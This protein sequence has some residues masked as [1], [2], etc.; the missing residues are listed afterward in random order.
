MRLL[1][2]LILSVL[3]C[4][5]AMAAAVYT[6]TLH[7]QYKGPAPVVS[8]SSAQQKWLQQKGQLTMGI[9]EP[10]YP[11]FDIIN[12]ENDYIGITADYASLISTALHI[13]V[14]V[15]VFGSR[16][17]AMAALA[18]NELDFLGT[19]N[20]FDQIDKNLVL[21][22]AYAEDNPVF[23][24]RSDIPVRHSEN[25]NGV[26]VA[27]VY[28]YLPSQWILE[29]YPDIKLKMYPS[30]FSAMGSVSFGQND[31]FLGDNISAEFLSGRRVFNNITIERR[32][33]LPKTQF[34]FALN[35]ENK[36]LL[37][38]LN[39][40]I[41]AVTP[42]QRQKILNHWGVKP[43]M[44]DK[45]NTVLFDEKELAWRDNH[46]VLRVALEDTNEPYSFFAAGGEPYGINADVLK[47]VAK[48][49][50]FRLVWHKVGNGAQARE[51]L[52]HGDV[53]LAVSVTDNLQPPPPGIRYS[54]TFYRDSYVV[55]SRLDS[56][57]NI[58]DIGDKP[59][60]VAVVDKDPILKVI[61]NEYPQMVPVISED[62]IAAFR[63]LRAKK[64]DIVVVSLAESVFMIDN[65]YKNRFKI[66]S[67]FTN[68]S[69]R[70]S[71]A[72]ADNRPELLAII[73]KALSSIPP[74]RMSELGNH[75][76]GQT[77]I[78][79][80]F[81]N[82]ERQQL[83]YGLLLL[84]VFLIILLGWVYWL[85]NLIK[86]RDKAESKL[87]DQLT[88]MRDLIDGTPLPIYVRDC[89]GKLL[90]CNTSYYQQLN[91]PENTVLGKTVFDMQNVQ[92]M[93]G[94][95]AEELE[96][97]YLQVIETGESI[98][99]DRILRLA[100][101]DYRI[102]HHW[103]MP[104]R[105]GKG[106]IIGVIGGWYD[107]SERHK[108]MERLQTDK[109]QAV[110]A[111]EAKSTFLTTMSH[112]IR[113]PMNVIIGMLELAVKKADA[114]IVDK[115]S[116][117]IASGEAQGLL[118]LIGD[119]LDIER[120]ESGYLSLNLQPENIGQL[121]SSLCRLFEA[122]ARRKGLEFSLDI[123]G[124][125][126]YG[127]LIDPLRFKQIISNLLSNAL[128]FTEQGKIT[129]SAAAHVESAE[130]LRLTITITDT[131]I[132]ISNEDC[133]KLFSRFSRASNNKLSSQQSSGLGL[134]I[135]KTLS[136]MMG[137]TLTL[138]SQPGQ[139]TSA[140]VILP[141]QRS[142]LPQS[143]SLPATVTEI[144][145]SRRVLIVDDYAANREVLTFQLNS[146]GHHVTAAADGSEGLAS[147]RRG[148]VDFVITDCSMPVMDG[149]ELT[150]RIRQEERTQNRLPVK[151]IG[152]TANAVN[153]ERQK[154]LDAGMDKCL[155]KPVTLAMLAALFETT[156]EPEDAP[157]GDENE[158][159]L[160]GLVALTNNDPG[161]LH[162]LLQT[163]ISGI[164]QDR[165]QLQTASASGDS[166]TLAAIAHR[167]R[168]GAEMI[169]AQAVIDACDTLEIVSENEENCDD[170]VS[171]LLAA[172]ETLSARLK[173]HM[174]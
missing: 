115:Y 105:T 24:R 166:Q 132:G 107:I 143:E 138:K 46:R 163:F 6:A 122:L 136:E 39:A 110:Q 156:P 29:A 169:N 131:G 124:T 121:I 18:R 152:L 62:A 89:N 47:E 60:R 66:D 101:N 1:G 130:R 69:L 3:L 146:L 76:R 56:N 9:T 30:N 8:L 137:G 148:D 145:A 99:S 41:Q 108:S 16:Q 5:Q 43:Q 109:D 26:S 80:N 170:A 126:D 27:M 98:I 100:Q 73:T 125:L 123:A 139:G 54:P 95:W 141:L 75:W 21:S 165:Q 49:S 172:L 86:Q 174:S 155:F 55:S 38:L 31:L 93:N 36:T 118:A 102:I 48:I 81:W 34:A 83:L 53:D 50:G 113:T 58:D 129:V 90:L 13:P 168:G 17:E 134:L 64:V 79:R 33:T 88:F 68:Q 23:A 171:E 173:R 142:A 114:G 11:P 61:K 32:A 97:T 135:C 117:N 150:R 14:T 19:S 77:V 12:F 161:K 128:K 52:E 10:G 94:G 87:N 40:V 160:S 106:E 140:V 4:T 119:I 104:Y 72:M 51:L 127:V 149:Y 167:I 35:H 78:E 159:D 103:I 28:N 154:C 15:K 59:L 111:S 74:A 153:E 44:I 112:E 147:W 42:E 85:R 7:G 82:K 2:W 151:I 162:P 67:V 37:S 144:Q 158:V 57:I 71:I 45:D 116:L 92:D 133:Q 22:E 65:F 164:Q 157:S 20:G 91:I 63:M 120:A 96:E 84:V 70:L 25:L